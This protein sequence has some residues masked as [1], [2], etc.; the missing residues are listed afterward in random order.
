MRLIAGFLVATCATAYADDKADVAAALDHHSASAVEAILADPVKVGPIVFE[1]AG[2]RKQFSKQVTVTGA[3]RQK[4]AACLGQSRVRP[5]GGFEMPALPLTWRD[6]FTQAMFTVT[7]ADHRIVAIGPWDPQGGE[8]AL[9]TLASTGLEARFKPS[10]PLRAEITAAST[11]PTA[12]VKSCAKGK[13]KI[14]S[15]IAVPS[16]NKAFDKEAGAYLAHFALSAKD[17]AAD[18]CTVWNLRAFIVKDIIQPVRIEKQDPGGGDYVEGGV[19]GGEPPPPPPPPPAPPQNVSPTM[20]EAQ[21]IAGSKEIRPD[22][23][24]KAKIV[25]SGKSRLIGSFKLCV[26]VHG[27]IASIS[28]LKSTGFPG[29]DATLDEGMRDWRYKPFMVNGR[30]VPVCTAVTFIFSP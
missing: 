30:A 27:E 25:Q 11:A 5:V 19:E 7:V 10:A 2:C 12:V 23:A 13:A 16:G 24:T 28:V 15:R 26:D 8:A 9:P 1:D 22:D 29:Y 20:L 21:R 18:T 4:L 3:D 14:T 17:V 6:I